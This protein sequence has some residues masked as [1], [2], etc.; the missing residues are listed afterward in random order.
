MAKEGTSHYAQGGHTNIYGQRG[1]SHC[2][3]GC[4]LTASRNERSRGGCWPRRLPGQTTRSDGSRSQER[5]D[6]GVTGRSLVVDLA[7]ALAGPRL[8]L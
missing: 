3:Q 4:Q 1:A 2:R 8:I 7:T 5:E 6:L